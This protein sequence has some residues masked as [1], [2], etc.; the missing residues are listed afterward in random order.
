[1]WLKRL[2]GKKAWISPYFTQVQQH[3]QVAFLRPPYSFNHNRPGSINFGVFPTNWWIH[4][5]SVKF[6]FLNFSYNC[7]SFSPLIVGR[8]DSQFLLESTF[9][10]S[11]L[12]FLFKL[13]HDLLHHTCS[14]IN[15]KVSLTFRTTW[16][17]NNFHSLYLFSPPLLPNQVA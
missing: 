6:E 12:E 2:K 15:A 17:V 9:N 10:S 1:M 11:R 16:I 3:F 14:F 8:L 5:S 4:S 13:L 7:F